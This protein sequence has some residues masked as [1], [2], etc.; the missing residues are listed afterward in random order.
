MLTSRL[1]PDPGFHMHGIP[2]ALPKRRAHEVPLVA[3]SLPAATLYLLHSAAARRASGGVLEEVG[4]P[5]PGAVC[6]QAAARAG[7]RRRQQLTA[8]D[9]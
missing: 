7:L 9:G 8:Q 5:E 3:C 4:H 1:A 6:V 2:V